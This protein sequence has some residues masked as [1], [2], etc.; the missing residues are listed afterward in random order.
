MGG[1]LSATLEIPAEGRGREGG[2]KEEEGW[3]DDD[4]SSLRG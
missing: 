3:R 1:E 2:R 4:A